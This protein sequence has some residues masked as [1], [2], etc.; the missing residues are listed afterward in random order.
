MSKLIKRGLLLATLL[1][2]ISGL[3]IYFT[4]D[5]ESLRTLNTF[6]ASS[7]L[8]AALA[9]SLGM[10]FDGKRLQ[11]LVKMGGYSLSIKA[12]LRVIFG[13]YFMAMLTPG[14]SGGAIAQMLILKSYGVPIIKGAPI[15][16]VRTVFS[17]FFLIVM[18]PIIFLHGSITI[19][20]ISN[21]TLLQLSLLMVLCT[22][23]GLYVL[24]TRYMKRLVLLGATRLKKGDPKAWLSKLTEL[25]EGLGL[26][27]A[28]PF[29]SLIVFIESGLS[30]LFLY[31]IAPALMWAFTINIPIVDILNRMILLNL[32]LYFAPTPGGTGVAEGLFIYLFTD[33][34]PAGTVGLVAVGWR[35]VAE[36]VPFFIGMY[37]VF[38]LYGHRFLAGEIDEHKED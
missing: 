7:L 35:I 13:N 2:L 14:A 30:L 5:M 20:Y 1:L 26:L 28:K 27:Y 17:I 12:I 4:I 11:R 29:Q 3:T 9:L 33:F 21:E 19:P 22:I 16:L 34:L 10:Y 37:S 36:Y 24:R 6:N 25:N 8:L 15:V 18:L 23:I 32:I 38:T 31:G